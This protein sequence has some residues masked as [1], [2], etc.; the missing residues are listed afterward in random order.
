MPRAAYIALEGKTTTLVC[1]DQIERLQFLEPADLKEV[2]ETPTPL[3]EPR[4]AAV[5]DGTE[6]GKP[7]R[8]GVAALEAGLRWEATYRVVIQER[9]AKTA[10]LELVATVDNQLAP[11]EETTLLLA[12]GVPHF[13][14]RPQ[15]QV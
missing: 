11:L 12:I 1:T 3:V 5:L 13:L 9:P 14:Y 4:L 6:D 7:L 10:R 15:L 8:L 2:K